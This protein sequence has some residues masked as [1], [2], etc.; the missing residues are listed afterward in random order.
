MSIKSIFFA[1]EKG[2]QENL[3]AIIKASKEINKKKYKIFRWE[4]LSVSGK[5]VSTD[6][7]NKIKSC[8]KFACDLTYLNHNVLF[9]LGFAIAQKKK[10]KIFL[11]PNIIDAKKN[12]SNLKILKNIGYKEFLN[13]NDIIKELQKP[14]LQEESLLL[15][16]KIIPGYKSIEIDKDIFLINIKNKNQAAIEV[17][18]YLSIEYNK[19]ITNNADEISYQPLKWYINSILRAKIVLLHMVGNESVEFKDTNA[20]YSLYAGLAYGLG[21]EVLMLAPEPFYAPIDYTD[22]LIEYSSYVDCLSKTLSWIN[23]HLKKEDNNFTN[24]I[25]KQEEIEKREL[26][27]LKLGIGEGV[28]EN[29]S[30]TSSKTFVE[31]DAY[32]E[33]IKRKKAII[34]GRKGSGK[35]EIFIRLKDEMINEKNNFNIIIKPDSD[36]MLS[37]VELNTLY[38][39]P[40]SQKAFLK[41]VWQYVISSKIFLNIYTN[42]DKLVLSENKKNDICVYYENNKEMFNYNFYN[43]IIYIARNFQGNDIIKDLSLLEKIKQKIYPMIKIINEYFNE[44]KY[45]KITIL[46]D[47]LDTGWEAKSDLNLQSLMIICLLEVCR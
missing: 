22:I 17:E 31:I 2:H 43:M 41:T 23:Q 37:N 47:N 8:D 45:Q 15:I 46:A 5:I 25:T 14:T 26:N 21:K 16:E 39:N 40:R 18:E 38:H 6:V 33:A 7:F 9:E 28:A 35:T 3:D 29:D 32:I 44:T 34:T 20:E 1:Y 24:E 19:F 4:E 36:E 11:N 13:A 10:L 12:Y 27:L 42:I 30:F